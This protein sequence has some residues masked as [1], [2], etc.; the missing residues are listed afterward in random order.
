[1]KA[2]QSEESKIVESNPDYFE[3][4]LISKE[5]FQIGY[6]VSIKKAT[7]YPKLEKYGNYNTVFNEIVS[8]ID[9]AFS[10]PKS[11]ID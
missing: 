10:E 6:F 1:M 4:K 9:N 3:N 2:H 5:W 11:K 8:S 7:W